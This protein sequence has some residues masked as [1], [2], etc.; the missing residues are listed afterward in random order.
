MNHV[1][2]DLFLNLFK[3]HLSVLYCFVFSL[4]II[5]LPK[6][7]M[8]G[9]QLLLKIDSYIFTMDIENF[10]YILIPSTFSF[11]YNGR[12]SPLVYQSVST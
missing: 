10:E 12:Y 5:S 3:T 8:E 1:S 11:E 6:I 7:A 9:Y 4:I 2:S